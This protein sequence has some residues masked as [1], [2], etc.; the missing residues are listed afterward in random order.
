MTKRLYTLGLTLALFN[1]AHPPALEAAVSDTPLIAAH[2]GTTTGAPENTLAAIR[3]ASR[4]GADFIETDLRM[5]AD[6]ELVLMHDDSVDRTTNGRGYVRDLTLGD[7]RQLDAG[8][9]E[10]IPTL[11]EVMILLSGSPQRLLLDVKTGEPA[12]ATRLVAAVSA[13]GFEHRVLVGVRSVDQ[14]R[15]IRSL[16][17]DLK[18]LAMAPKPTD[19]NDFLK[20]RPDG[21]RLWARWAQSDPGLARAVRDGGAQVWIMAGDR[22]PAHLRDLL[23]LADG[24]IT[25]LPQELRRYAESDSH[26]DLTSR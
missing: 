8:A 12:L 17:P 26:G 15:E 22:R 11:D 2:R 23:S 25:D 6:G 16:N 4:Y 20:Y 10:R 14:L 18:L 21:V 5:T 9:G 13:H 3:W 19:V 7:L 1:V 24:F